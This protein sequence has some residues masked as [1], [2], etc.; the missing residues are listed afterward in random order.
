MRT[1]YLDCSMGAAGDMLTAALLDLHPEPA[2]FLAR[3]NGL[4]IPNVTFEVEKAARC[5]ISGT[6]MRVKVGGKEEASEDFNHE[7]LHD[8][9]HHHSRENFHEESHEHHSE[10]HCEHSEFCHHEHDEENSHREHSHSAEHCHHHEHSEHHETHSP[11][12]SELH[13]EHHHEHHGMADIEKVV[14]SLAVPEAVKRDVLAVYKLIAEAE[15]KVH[16]RSVTEIHFHEV[17]AMDA[18]ADVTAV[19]LLLHELAPERIAASPV[20]TG[21]GQVKC[22]HGIL[23]VPAPAT[24]LLLQGVPSYGGQIRGELCTPTGAAL[25]KHFAT[26]FGSQPAMRVEKLGYGLGKK[27]FQAANCVRAALGETAETS[28]TDEVLELKCNLDDMTA[29]AL[30]FAA[31]ELLAAGALDVFTAAIGM[32]KSRP[33]VLLTCLCRAAEREKFIR[34]IFRHTTTLG[35]RETLCKRSVLTRELKTLETDLGAVRVKCVSGYGVHRAKIEHDDLAKIAQSKKLS[36]SEAEKL[37]RESAA[38]KALTQNP[39]P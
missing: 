30:A 23:P 29:E 11:E 3:L 24:A 21:F 14:N 17:G 28:T 32:K 25:L 5:G 8:H 39:E 26:S 9:C 33:A 19:S 12:H 31:E 4:G 36:L 10:A 20:C 35:I 38:F 22:A 13:H 18:V 16:G 27:E 1:L 34:L 15:S 37:V 6:L 2:K 7:L